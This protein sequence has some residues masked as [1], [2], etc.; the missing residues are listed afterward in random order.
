M[1]S[2]LLPAVNV[3]QICK[4]SMLFNEKSIVE[5]IKQYGLKRTMILINIQLEKKKI[6]RELRNFF[7]N[8]SSL[9]KKHYGTF[10]R[11]DKEFDRMGIVRV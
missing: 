7:G 4:D 11:I 5:Y 1:P 3:K 10:D 9:L 8:C 6:S 2:P